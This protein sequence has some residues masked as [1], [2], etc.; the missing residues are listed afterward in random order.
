MNAIVPLAL[1]AGLLFLMGSGNAS[2]KSKPKTAADYQSRIA[3]AISAGDHAE[4]YRIADEMH[5]AGLAV[6]AQ[7]LRNTAQG[8]EALSKTAPP[9]APVI[10]P[11]PAVPNPPIVVPPVIVPSPVPLPAGVPITPAEQARRTLAQQLAVNLRNTSVYNEDRGLV[12][13]FQLQEAL[14]QDGLYGPRT[15]EALIRYGIVPPRPRYWAKKT[16]SAEKTAWRA[17]MNAQATRDPA[18]AADWHAAAK[19]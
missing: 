10:A 14:K 18:R 11:S 17:L 12:K 4:L 19:V 3:A 13:R 15:A 1:G 7:A 9:G 2:A 8:L 6:E 16:V 5:R